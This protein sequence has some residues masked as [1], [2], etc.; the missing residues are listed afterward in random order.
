M[1]VPCVLSE[2]P[3]PH[4]LFYINL[5]VK[6]LAEVQHSLFISPIELSVNNSQL[7]TLMC[8]V[9]KKSSK[10]FSDLRKMGQQEHVCTHMKYY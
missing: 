4:M 9:D 3:P 10:T 7:V 5:S 2:I 1:P 8:L 6:L